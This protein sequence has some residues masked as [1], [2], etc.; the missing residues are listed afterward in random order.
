MISQINIVDDDDGE[1]IGG[2]V[3]K[4]D[5]TVTCLQVSWLVTLHP[6]SAVAFPAFDLE[7]RPSA[8]Q[9]VFRAQT[10]KKWPV[11]V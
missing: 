6:S 10:L 11:S 2:G 9:G 5:G 4:A 1:G 8:A 3:A 7:K